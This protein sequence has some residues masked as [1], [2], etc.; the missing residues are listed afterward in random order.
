MTNALPDQ[1][2]QNLAAM[3]ATQ[4]LQSLEQQ[5]ASLEESKK[6]LAKEQLDYE[7]LLAKQLKDH[8]AKISSQAASFTAEKMKLTME[9]EA[10]KLAALD[11]QKEALDNKHEADLKEAKPPE[12]GDQKAEGARLLAPREMRESLQRLGQQGGAAQEESEADA[13]R[14]PTLPG[15]E[16]LFNT[17]PVEGP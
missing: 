14:A 4:K 16:L 6:K 17:V 7:A 10:K 13:L 9:L 15:L 1:G 5:V 8:E 2:A 11:E 3:E 12:N